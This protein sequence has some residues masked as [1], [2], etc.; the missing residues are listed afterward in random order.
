MKFGA[1]ACPR[2]VFVVECKERGGSIEVARTFEAFSH[3]SSPREAASQINRLLASASAARAAVAVA[4]RGFGEEWTPSGESGS[5]HDSVSAVTDPAIAKIF[6][7]Q[8][9]ASGHSL[10]H[11]TVLP[12]AMHRI[13]ADFAS[14]AQPSLIIAQFPDAPFL[15]YVVDGALCHVVEPQTSEFAPLSATELAEEAELGAEFV[16]QQFRGG[17]VGRAMLLTSADSFSELESAIGARLEVPV[18]QLPLTGLSAGSVA[19]FGAVLD[20]ESLHP[21]SLGGNSAAFAGMARPII[22]GALALAATAVVWFTAPTWEDKLFTS[23]VDSLKATAPAARPTTTAQA[24]DRVPQQAAAG[25]PDDSARS[26]T[27]AKGVEP[28]TVSRTGVSERRLT[29]IIIAGNRP[30]AVV[31]DKVVEVGDKLADGARVDAIQSDRVRLVDSTGR[32]RVLTLMA[33]R[34]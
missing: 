29:A 5:R 6:S 3:V 20:A 34:R 25:R 26:A 33:G 28:S 9:A 24:P 10:R 21:V 23:A 14:D 32:R 19:A 22:A 13:V 2:G 31:D 18:G 11:L 7:E 27:V 15:G 8:L 17:R 1:F 12:A 16:R 4:V 30:T